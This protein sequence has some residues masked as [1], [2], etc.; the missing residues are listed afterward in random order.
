[1]YTR[2]CEWMRLQKS[3]PQDD[4]QS[5]QW[6]RYAFCTLAPPVR[7]EAQARVRKSAI[8]EVPTSNN[9]DLHLKLVC[10]QAALQSL[11]SYPNFEL[12][13]VNEWMWL[14]WVKRH[15]QWINV[16]QL[17][18]MGY[19]SL[20]VEKKRETAQDWQ[21]DKL[22][23]LRA[24]LTSPKPVGLIVSFSVTLLWNSANCESLLRTANSNSHTWASTKT[25]I[26][27]A[28]SYD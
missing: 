25:S 5:L 7:N 20:R 4:K 3:P 15:W 19:P 14:F 12:L 17:H 8:C 10:P 18:Q 26:N 6:C 28:M 11:Q 24:S 13:P 1:M 23:M 22:H 16:H 2:E 9:S 21:A 27:G